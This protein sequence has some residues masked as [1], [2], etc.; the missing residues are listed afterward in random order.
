MALRL[1]KVIVGKEYGKDLRALLGEHP[2]H[3]RWD[4]ELD[5]E[6]VEANVLLDSEDTEPVLDDLADNFE[7]GEE[8]RVVVMTVEAMLPRPTDEDGDGKPD[9]R[10]E[11][12]AGIGR[13]SR[14][15]LYNNVSDS[16]RFTPLWMTMVAL[17]AVVASAG[18]MRDNVAVV[19]GAMVIAPLLGPNIAL[20]LAATLGDLKLALRA[21]KANAAGV[22]LVIAMSLLAGLI[23]Q[24]SGSIDAIAD[25]SSVS[26][27]DI[28]LALAA[29]VAGTLAFTS[30]TSAVLVGVM[31]AV[32]L[33]PPTVVC[34]LM[35]GTGDWDAAIAAGLLV[36]VNILCINLAGMATFA[37]QGIRPRC[38]YEADVA[39]KATRRALIAMGVLL[40][41]LAAIIG[42]VYD[43]LGFVN[44]ANG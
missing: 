28:A 4:D 17:S 35:V 20:A 18:L 43:W 30:G 38:Y 3:G 22:G 29:G 26:L 42:Y 25:R 9:A 1:L 11:A 19:I 37:L 6:L 23:F 21:A 33:L 27:T 15:E 16:V 12:G 10:N 36:V 40:L 2:I 34:G 24:P 5:D 39:R 41:I 13:I 31:V 32:A 44:G 14:E 8:F 7:H